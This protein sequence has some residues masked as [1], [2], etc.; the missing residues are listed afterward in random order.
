MWMGTV[1]QQVRLQGRDPLA[2]VG[3]TRMEDLAEV[4]WFAEVD[5]GEYLQDE[6]GL[7]R[8]NTRVSLSLQLMKA[9][10]LAESYYILS[11]FIAIC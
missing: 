2:V 8:A 10:V 9:T 7:R 6:R 3:G 1:L 4:G 11:I 5:G